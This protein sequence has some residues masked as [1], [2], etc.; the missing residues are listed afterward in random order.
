MIL[1]CVGKVLFG[2]KLGVAGKV[3]FD[4]VLKSRKGIEPIYGFFSISKAN[5][6]AS[7]LNFPL[8]CCF[9]QRKDFRYRSRIASRSFQPPFLFLCIKTN[10]PCQIR[11]GFLFTKKLEACSGGRNSVKGAF[12]RGKPQAF[13]VRQRLERI[14]PAAPPASPHRDID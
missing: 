13:C 12:E 10:K 1:D 6:N 5:A 2:A 7:T 11:Q 4:R 8:H 3:R 14:S 9:A